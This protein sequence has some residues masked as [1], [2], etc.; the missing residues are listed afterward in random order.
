MGHEAMSGNGSDTHYPYFRNP[1]HNLYPDGLEDPLVEE[2]WRAQQFDDITHG[3]TDDPTRI[4]GVPEEEYGSEL[5]KL[6]GGVDDD[7]IE[8]NDQHKRPEDLDDE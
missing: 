1:N 8:E 3:L 2:E 7:E 4:F 5:D 6:A